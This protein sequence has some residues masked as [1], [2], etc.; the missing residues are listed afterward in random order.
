MSPFD[1]RMPRYQSYMLRCWEICSQHPNQST[2]WRFSLE[3]P[4]TGEKIGFADLDALVTF[5]R[6]EF[7]TSDGLSLYESQNEKEG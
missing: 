6:T 4:R 7:K 2:I 5:M 1:Y 3:D